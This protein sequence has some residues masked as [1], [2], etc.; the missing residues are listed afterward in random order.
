MRATSDHL[1]TLIVGRSLIVFVQVEDLFG[2]VGARWP[3]RIPLK[4]ES[5]G[6]F[7]DPCWRAPAWV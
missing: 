2:A 1:N 4:N 3:L 7:L 5:S 6:R